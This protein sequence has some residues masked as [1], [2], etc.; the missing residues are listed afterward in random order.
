MALPTTAIVV[1]DTRPLAWIFSKRPFGSTRRASRSRP[2]RFGC[3]GELVDE[4]L[5]VLCGVPRGIEEDPDLDAPASRG[6]GLLEET[7]PGGADADLDDAEGLLGP[8]NERD[9]SR[10]SA[11]SGAR[12]NSTP[13]TVTDPGGCTGSKASA[14]VGGMVRHRGPP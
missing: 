9:L 3:L 5:V 7:E 1:V 4:L 6:D 8:P 12:S 10:G 11:L 13:S 2:S 14:G